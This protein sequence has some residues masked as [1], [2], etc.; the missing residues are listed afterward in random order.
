MYTSTLGPNI[1]AVSPN[2]NGL[3]LMYPFPDM[4][5]SGFSEYKFQ[6]CILVSKK[7]LRALAVLNGTFFLKAPYSVSIDPFS[8]LKNLCSPLC[9]CIHFLWDLPFL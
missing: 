4:C 7:Y 3:F 6:S 2:C 9:Q 1:L 5:Q 8:Y